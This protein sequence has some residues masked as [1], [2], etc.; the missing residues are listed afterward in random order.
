MA[1]I[2]AQI[3][4]YVATFLF[5]FA[6]FFFMLNKAKIGQK[7]INVVLA[8]AIGIFSAAYQP[9]V[10]GL[11]E[12]LP[13]AVIFIII[14]FALSLIR[15]MIGGIGADSLPAASALAASLLLVAVLWDRISPLLPGFI[16]PN[17]ALWIIG[18]V[19]V[20]AL[21]YVVYTHGKP[22]APQH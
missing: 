19:M 16:S 6:I 8:A 13:L 1:F 20:A 9:L 17:N 22:P 4:P 18:I 3:V 21:L 7:N 5:V 15:D 2:D 11:Q 12:I 10:D 14:L